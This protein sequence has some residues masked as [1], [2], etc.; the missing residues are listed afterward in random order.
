MATW[1]EDDKSAWPGRRAIHRHHRQ[2]GC[3]VA[4]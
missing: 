2:V 4:V 3:T 1:P